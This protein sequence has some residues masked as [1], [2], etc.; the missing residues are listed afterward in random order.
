VSLDRVTPTLTSSTDQLDLDLV[1]SWRRDFGPHW[2]ALLDAGVRG[3]VP[4]D[5]QH[6]PVL[7]PTVGGQLGYFPHW[8][9]ASLSVR[10]AVAPNLYLARNTVTDVAVASAWLPL[11]WLAPERARPTL[12]VQ[13]TAGVQRARLIDADGTLASGFDLV[14]GDLALTYAPREGLAVTARVQHLRQLGASGAVMDIFDY[15]RTTVMISATGRFP[16]RMAAEI[17]I[18]SSLRVDRSDVTPVG[19]E[20]T[21]AQAPATAP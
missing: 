8:G 2:T 16:G 11:P 9:N 15:D 5:D 21:P 20:T 3:I 12:S 18:R 14:T 1:G 7:Q 13:G 4:L 6:D 10:R 17:P 19:N